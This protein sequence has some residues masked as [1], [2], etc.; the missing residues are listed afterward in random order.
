M[1]G[2]GL[3]SLSEVDVGGGIGRRGRGEMIGVGCLHAG[4]ASMC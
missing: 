3:G 2:P 4:P 1:F